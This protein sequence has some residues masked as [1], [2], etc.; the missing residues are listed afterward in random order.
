VKKLRKRYTP[1][2]YRREAE[3][4]FDRLFE[5]FAGSTIALSYSSNG[6][7]DL[8]QLV[9]ALGRYKSNVTVHKEEHRYHF[10]THGAVNPERARVTEYL[11]IGE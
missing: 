10:G 3:S 9:E 2:S 8:P 7:P 4:A 5:R 1:F 6:F 11:L